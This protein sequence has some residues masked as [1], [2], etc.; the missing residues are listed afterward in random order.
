M[1]TFRSLVALGDHIDFGFS[2]NPSCPKPGKT[3]CCRSDRTTGTRNTRLNL[4]DAHL[5]RASVGCHWFNAH[6]TWG[7]AWTP[8]VSAGLTVQLVDGQPVPLAFLPLE[9]RKKTL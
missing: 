2:N 3:G 8:S 4:S 6:Q 5:R 9:D 1:R 7:D